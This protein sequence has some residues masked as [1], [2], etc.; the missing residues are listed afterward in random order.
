MNQPTRYEVRKHGEPVLRFRARPGVLLSTA[1]RPMGFVP[2]K[3]AFVDAQAL[4]AS[5]EA[6]LGALLTQV[7]SS[8]AFIQALRDAGFD[9]HEVA[10]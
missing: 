4:D 7:D 2:P 8:T 9:V 3:H 10:P 1:P 6:E 5:C